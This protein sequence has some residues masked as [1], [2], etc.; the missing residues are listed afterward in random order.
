MMNKEQ[1]NASQEYQYLQFVDFKNL[2]F[3]DRAIKQSH[4][5]E[6]NEKGFVSFSQ[7]ISKSDVIEKTF[8][9]GQQ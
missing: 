3:W 8:L 9:Y 6:R 7:A 4:N 5:K 2:G 1:I